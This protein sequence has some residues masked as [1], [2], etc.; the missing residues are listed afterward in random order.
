MLF[1]IKVEPRFFVNPFRATRAVVGSGRPLTAMVRALEANCYRLGRAI[2]RTESNT[3]AW[4]KS[5]VAVILNKICDFMGVSNLRNLPKV[6]KLN[7]GN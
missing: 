3:F 2:G 4:T 7:K 5:G 6:P 1:P